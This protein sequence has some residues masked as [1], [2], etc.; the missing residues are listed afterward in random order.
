MDGMVVGNFVIIG[1]MLGILVYV[2][3]YIEFVGYLNIMY[4]FGSEEL[5]IFICVFIGVL[6]GFLWYNVYLVQVFMG[7]IGSLIIGGIIVV[8]VIIIY[9]E[10]LILIFCGIF[11]VENFLVF[12]QCFYYKV[13]KRKGIK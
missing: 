6:I 7:D 12:L 4:I 2:L 5:V 13:G 8:F 11:L 1:L 3:S 9:K 10:L